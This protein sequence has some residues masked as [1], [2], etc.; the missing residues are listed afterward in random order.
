MKETNLKTDKP[1]RD[2]DIYKQVR[3]RKAQTTSS[4]DSVKWVQINKKTN[5][6]SINSSSSMQ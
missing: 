1:I 3:D 2:N 4:N 6:K 5:S